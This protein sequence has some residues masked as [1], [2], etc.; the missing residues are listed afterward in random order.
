MKLSQ[1]DPGEKKAILIVH[2]DDSS[3]RGLAL[4]FGRKGSEVETARTGQEALDKARGRFFDAVLLDIRMPDIAGV[5]L[6]A[7]LKALHPD[8]VIIMV[9]SH[10]SLETAVQAQD[11]G[12]SAYITKPLN[13]DEVLGRV[14]DA[15]EKQ[16]L[17][18]ANRRLLREL[19]QELTE[20][21]RAEA[22]IR[23][24]NRRL[25]A[26]HQVSQA[27]SG[28]LNLE[29][30][31]TLALEAFIRGLD[32]DTGVIRYLDETTQELVLLSQRGMPPEAALQLHGNLFRTKLGQGLSGMAAQSE[33]PVVIDDL[34]RDARLHMTSTWRQLGFTCAVGLPL[35]VKG[36]VVGTIAG[37]SRRRRT[38]SPAEIEMIASFGNMVGM[39]IANARLFEQSRQRA[40]RM[41]AVQQVSEAVSGSLN[42]EAVAALALEAS[43]RVLDMDAGIIRYLDEATQEMVLL[44]HRGLP[45]EM[46]K[47]RQ[48]NPRLT[49]RESTTIGRV[50]QSGEPQV[51][52]G[53]SQSTDADHR[54]NRASGFDSVIR[55]PLKVKGTVVGML[56]CISRRRRTFSPREMEMITSIGNMVGMAIANARLY[57]ESQAKGQSLER[58]LSKQELSVKVLDRLNNPGAMED[59][60][61]DVLLLI[62]EHSGCEAVG[63]RFREG[64]GFPYYVADGFVSGHVEA[65]NYLCARDMDGQ[66][67]RD[68]IGNPVLECMCGNVIRGRFDPEK[69]FFT[70]G[71]CFWT[72]STTDL[73][74]ST[75][76]EDRQSRTCDRCHG[77]SYESVAL[78]PLRAEMENIGLLQLNDSQR[79]RFSLELIEFYEGL[80]QA[81][82]V[83]LRHP[84]AQ[85]ALLKAQAEL[86]TRVKERTIELEKAN[87]D[88]GAEVTEHARAGKRLR[89]VSKRLVQ[90][91]EDERR[92]IAREL[93]D[94]IGQ[95][96]TM[97]TFLLHKARIS[98]NENKTSDLQEM[99][100]ALVGVIQEVRQ[101][102][103]NLRPSVLDDQGLLPALLWYIGSYTT[104]TGVHVDFQHAG[105]DRNLPTDIRTA[106]YRIV[107]E[108]LT[109]V[110]RHASVSEAKLR[111]R[112]ENN[113]LYVLI[114]DQG[115]GFN[116]RGM[117]IGSFSGVNGMRERAL[118]LGGTVTVRS[119]PGAGTCVAAELPLSQPLEAKTKQRR[120]G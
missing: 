80:G 53:F 28:S 111:A 93:H 11:Q 68:E 10:A 89:A 7:P 54:S 25:E 50:V 97:L 21:K 86:E 1:E 120:Q 43:V 18:V 2:D 113:T 96:L 114:E 73:L 14:R 110:A 66:L 56:S 76:E 75:T 29:T 77:E 38:F 51:A 83:A 91:Q 40:R 118:L 27:V 57:E 82:G 104:K 70:R 74:A 87:R 95:S 55:L 17:I 45:E 47:E 71:G 41:E 64:E 32:M 81:I 99:K 5:D 36:R 6:I 3:L 20:R 108:A 79:G 46:V 85:E 88:L 44:C 60:V 116:S 9:T 112:V 52:H 13:T 84:Q 67:L 61:R 92:R 16:S 26:L 19:E 33:T 31:A 100:V 48:E 4:I 8:T 63:L 39:A 24:Y 62:R 94:Q 69:P 109:N 119:N 78:I 106:A 98:S 58:S 37:F 30:V 117:P 107:Q 59:L 23:E 115:S 34:S 90:A 103:L 12:A 15:L 72:N 101:M 102:S 22:E 65:E 105:L 35:K 49:I 42:L